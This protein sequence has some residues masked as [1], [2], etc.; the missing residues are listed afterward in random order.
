MGYEIKLFIGLA[1]TQRGKNRDYSTTPP[2]EL[3]GERTYFMRYA[4]IDLCKLAY[5]G[6]FHAAMDSWKNTDPNH[7]WYAFS[8]DG[9]THITKDLYGERW[10]PQPISVVLEVLKKD[11]ENDDY[12]RLKWAIALLESMKDDDENLSVWIY[13][14]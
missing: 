5:S 11:A 9:N 6:A 14:H 12:R 3:G 7:E 13:G 2:T 4:T 1:T 10:V 8:D